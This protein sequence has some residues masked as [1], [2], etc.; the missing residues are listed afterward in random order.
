MKCKSIKK[1][2]IS[3]GLLL[4]TFLSYV[5]P[6]PLITNTSA[7]SEC[8]SL[9]RV[10]QR[11]LLDAL[12]PDDIAGVDTQRKFVV[13]S[14]SSGV[15][16][17]TIKEKLLE[18]YPD[19]FQRLLLYATR[20]RRGLKIPTSDHRYP[21]IN[22]YIEMVKSGRNFSSM[23]DFLNS[24]PEEEKVIIKGKIK[25][26]S[27]KQRAELNEV[28]FPDWKKILTGAPRNDVPSIEERFKVSNEEIIAYKEFNGVHY[29]FVSEE[30]LF[31]LR[32]EKGVIVEPVR[33]YYQG[34]DPMHVKEALKDL[35]KILILEGDR[36]WFD[37]VHRLFPEATSIF[38]APISIEEFKQRMVDELGQ[39]Y[40]EEVKVLDIRELLRGGIERFIAQNQQE[41]VKFPEGLS[42]DENKA[43]LN[44]RNAILAAVGYKILHPETD[45][46]EWL[47]KT[48]LLQASNLDKVN[49]KIGK[50]LT[51]QNV[52]EIAN[53]VYNE[54]AENQLRLTAMKIIMKE[55]VRRIEYRWRSQGKDPQAV[56]QLRETYVRAS[57]SPREYGGSGDYDFMLVHRWNHLD[58][59]VCNFTVL[60]LEKLYQ[61]II[62]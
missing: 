36:V 20:A 4:L 62:K 16:Q 60:I 43:F 35:D 15:G 51:T 50:N 58:D 39:E 28:L 59:S 6:F 53:N 19:R 5:T 42:P 30:E 44:V 1:I 18:L 34:L 10:K 29:W 46:G 54:I 14:G 26:L 40:Q 24:L 21:V 8:L 25:E 52:I 22:A 13:H 31:K 37:H 49:N 33:D 11:F 41:L 9:R 57:Q 32:D 38:I 3:F 17:G 45:I 61:D 55:M 56:S 27:D 7:V 23:E 47:K 48:D 2:S 12:T